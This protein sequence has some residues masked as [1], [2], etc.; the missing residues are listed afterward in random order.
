MG[1]FSVEIYALPGSL[2]SGNQHTAVAPA[3]SAET[4]AIVIGVVDISER[5]AARA[6]VE[7]LQIDLTHA[8]RVSMLGELTASIAHEVNQPLAAIATNGQAGLLWLSRT[9]VDLEEVREITTSMVADAHRAADIIARIRAMA[10]KRAPERSRAAINPIVEEAVLFLNHELQSAGVMLKI[11]LAPAL[12]DADIDR[13]QI[14]QV[15]VNLAMNAIQAMATTDRAQRAINIATRQADGAIEVTIAD[16]GPGIAGENI[17]RLFDS[18]F[19]T[20]EG[21]LGIGLPIC[22]SIVEAHGGTI[23]AINTKPSGAQF[24]FTIAAD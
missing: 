8:A 3:N 1:Q 15:I 9:E 13:T 17:E 21:G 14:Q 24:I 19:T 20:K 2:L 6:A 12:S 10:A 16:S 22:R 7:R 23:H 11:D 18:F 5:V 4:G